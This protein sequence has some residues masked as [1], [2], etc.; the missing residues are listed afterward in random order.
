MF[1][2]GA[3]VF[4]MKSRSESDSETTIF[5]SVRVGRNT[6]IGADSQI[7][8]GVVI[9]ENC[10]LAGRC[11]IEE[12]QVIP[13]ES[14][15][16]GIPAKVYPR[17]ST[18]QFTSIQGWDNH[19]IRFVK[20]VG[21]IAVIL[22]ALAGFLWPGYE[23]VRFLW[24]HY[25]NRILSYFSLYM[26]YI[27]FQILKVLFSI[28]GKWVLI[29]RYDVVFEATERITAYLLSWQLFAMNTP[30]FLNLTLGS[31][32]YNL[33]L[34]SLGVTIGRSTFIDSTSVF[35]LDM[36]TIGSHCIVSQ[37][38]NVFGHSFEGDGMEFGSIKIEDYVILHPR[39]FVT[40][41]N[42]MGHCSELLPGAFPFPR[43]QIQCH[44]V[45][46][47]VP[48]RLVTQKKWGKPQQE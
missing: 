31:P 30:S 8:S 5:K 25:R 23:L 1:V 11:I 47:G 17:A 42:V 6:W 7:K 4:K 36:V 45:W 48:A 14:M 21:G 16:I 44:S 19:T 46:G 2:D 38:T 33:Y 34:R 10:R 9:G 18:S 37:K 20:Q 41:E 26:W 27:I 28:I 24:R 29:G 39:S 12:G 22:A 3:V 40:R 13:D 43:E 15:C 35:D 32:L